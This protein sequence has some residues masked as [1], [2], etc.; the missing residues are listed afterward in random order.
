MRA[1]VS[2][3]LHRARQGAGRARAIFR[4]LVRIARVVARILSQLAT[5]AWRTVSSRWRRRPEPP[6]RIG[7]DVSPYYEPLTGVGWY[8][9]EILTELSA[10]PDVDIIAYG[11]AAV[12]D[13]SPGLQV[14]LPTGIPLHQFDLRGMQLPWLAG[15]IAAASQRLLV[16]ADGCDVLWGPNYFLPRRL[17]RSGKPEVF[18]IHDLTWKRFPELLQKETLEALEKKMQRTIHDA[19]AL[20]T[21]S[22]A[23]RHDVLENFDL[24]PSR[25]HTVLSGIRRFDSSPDTSRTQRPYILFVSTIEPRKNL[26]VLIDAYE[27]LRS[28]G[29]YQGRLLVAG[30]VGW[31]SEET[32]RRLR[33][34]RWSADITHLDYVTRPELARL[35]SGADVFVLPSRYEG[36][37]L[38]ILEAMSFDTPVICADVSSMPEVGGDAVLYFQPDDAAE[39]ARRIR[40]IVDDPPLRAVLVERGRKRVAELTWTRAAEE[41]LRVMKKAASR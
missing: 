29:E 17:E 30:R 38:P 12:T 28:R 27:L 16:Y 36:F 2:G 20:I 9:H 6:F 13:G 8:L 23:T 14:E 5:T 34:S 35:Y 1:L 10:R 19:A 40:E 18:T 3:A 11:E 31:K 22:E 41:T 26:D 33:T 21:V 25:A 39:L 32:I 37:G 15:R 4:E 24:A 7:V